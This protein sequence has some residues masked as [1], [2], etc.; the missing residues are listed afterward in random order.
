MSPIDRLVPFASD[1]DGGVAIVVSL[2]LTVLLGFVALGVDVASIYRE[3]AQLQSVS[4][5]AAMGAMAVPE[6]AVDRATYVISRN[7][8]TAEALKTFQSG[9]F[10]R[11]PAVAPKDRFT[12]L[13]EGSRGINA[14]RV[15][16]QD[17]APLHFARIFSD[18]N[19]VSMNRT[20]LAT[21][22]GA[23]SFSLDSHLAS[24]D[25]AALNQA[26]GQRFGVGASLS[27]AD[28]NALAGATVDLGTL[29]AALDTQVGGTARNPAEVLNATTSVADLI[30]SLQSVLP[31]S[32]AYR[33]ETLAIAS[34]FDTV[35]VSALV[36]GIDTE[37]GLSATEFL[38][39]IEVS[40]LDV[41]K[42][43]IAT[44]ASDQGIAVASNVAVP[45]VISASTTLTAG[46]PPAHSGWIALGEEGV[47]LH[48]A[49][50]RLRSDV[51]VETGTLGNLGVGVQVAKI[52][53]PIYLELAG[54]TATLDK[55][56]CNVTD[57][58]DVAARF[59]TAHTPLHPA[60]GTSVAA[61]YL[62]SLPNTISS[63]SSI[64]PDA[65]GFAD[66]LDLNIV[67]DLPLLPDLAI[68]GITIQAR[69]HLSV[70]ASQQDTIT[71]THD[72]I[73]NDTTTRF[74]GSGD[75][76][77]TAIGDLLS[78]Q[79]LEL[80]VKPGQ[81]GLVSGLAAPVM[82][83]VLNLLPGRLLSGLA[84]PIDGILDSTLASVG[85][86]LGTGE[87]T[88]TGHHCEPIRLVR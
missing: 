48:R 39:Q 54:S 78:P 23:A 68:S 10:L 33:L 30:T 85:L 66:L 1:E 19:H 40:A 53:L 21:R 5:L 34:G 83:G 11:N 81:A 74:F 55:I 12:V 56:G 45:G 86:E 8:K 84:G 64:N 87:L 82:T 32:V 47:Q 17:E 41:V 52:N 71:F 14:V 20:A 80:R 44:T 27:V 31:S 25:R 60:N 51:S 6:D 88:L 7:A 75:L 24:L 79:K 28:M 65:L 42:A 46:E 15:V 4:D 43:L 37:L 49:A 58:L 36:G 72:D 3:R 61:L 76:L 38:S 57:P 2:L 63:T 69:S 29:L 70:G 62:G 22:T 73:A 35:A 9:R 26:L 18:A 77:A 16:L 67:I 59:L 13:P 50:V